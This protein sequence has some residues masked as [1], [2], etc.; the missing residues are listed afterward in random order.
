M[1]GFKFLKLQQPM[2][3][4]AHTNIHRCKKYSHVIHFLM[5]SYTN[6]WSFLC[7]TLLFIRKNIDSEA[8]LVGTTLLYVIWIRVF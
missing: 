5:R 6:S 8:L 2:K 4:V 7:V 3:L 1:I